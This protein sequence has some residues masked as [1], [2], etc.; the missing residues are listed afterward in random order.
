MEQNEREGEEQQY[1]EE[2]FKGA[3]KEETNKNWYQ[4][5]GDSIQDQWWN[6]KGWLRG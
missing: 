6:L 3:I 5:L 4:R 1:A 2:L